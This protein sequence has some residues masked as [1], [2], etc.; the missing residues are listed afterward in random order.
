MLGTNKLR[1]EEIILKI[2]RDKKTKKHSRNNY[3]TYRLGPDIF[4]CHKKI[5]SLLDKKIKSLNFIMNFINININLFYCNFKGDI[6][7]ADKKK[8]KKNDIK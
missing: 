7:E 4:K 2:L 5:T 8:A 3:V 6:S 1:K